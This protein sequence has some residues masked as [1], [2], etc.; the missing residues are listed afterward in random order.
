MTAKEYLRQLKML[1]CLIKAKE[2]EKERLMALAG[3]VSVSLSEKVQGGS[4]GGTENAIIDSVDLEK[5]ITADIKKLV[6]LL[7]EAR[8]FINK[9]D[10]ERYKAV[11][12]MRY[13]SDM[14]FEM[15]ADTMHYSLGTIHN[16]HA[17]GLKEFDKVFSEKK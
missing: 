3:K 6:E 2:L 10:N 1:D 14:T 8:G 17:R 12:S 4:G 11:L 16:L 15:I 9:L 7:E 13:I 5:E